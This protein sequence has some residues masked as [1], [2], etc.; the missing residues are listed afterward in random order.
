[1]KISVEWL[2]QYVD[3]DGSVEQLG[4]LFTRIGFTLE[5]SRQVGDDWM[6]DL[7]ITSNRPDCLGHIGL[8]REIAAA[9]GAR[10]HMPEL[11]LAD[12]TEQSNAVKPVEQWVSVEDNVPELCR[13]Y[14]ARVVDGVRVGDSPEWMRRRLEVIGQRSINNVVDVTN[15]VLM[16]IGQPLHSF[17][18]DKL[19]GG[20]VV[21][22]MARKGE[23]M[24]TIDQSEVVLDV[25]D[26][27][28]ADNDG[29]V[30]LAGVMGGLASEVGEDT[31]TVLLESAHF[32]PLSVRRTSRKLGIGSE[33]SYRF[34]R[35]VDIVMLEWASR[36]AASLLAELAGGKIAAGVIDV[37]PEQR[38]PRKV[39]LRMARLKKLLGIEIDSD[40][41]WELFGRLGFGCEFEQA[42]GA[43]GVVHCVIPSWRSDI[44]READLIEE[45]IR[46][47]GY[48]RI[49][50]EKSIRITVTTPDKT[51]RCRGR[52]VQAL[53]GCGLYET[54]NVSFLE[55]NY[56]RAFAGED[57]EPVR[58][59]DVSRKS[60]NA[61]RH[62]LLPSLLLARKRNQDAG[63]ERCDMYELGAVH[64]W[65]FEGFVG[66]N[67]T[68][69]GGRCATE[70]ESV[71]RGK[72]V[73]GKAGRLPEEAIKIGLCSDGEFRELRGVVEAVVGSLDRR[74]GVVLKPAN[75][76]W[77]ET[78]RAA[79][80]YIKQGGGQIL[81]GVM[82]QVSKKTADV[83]DLKC[84]PCMADIDFGVL[85]AL[86]G[87]VGKFRDFAR[88]PGIVR[89]LS[90]V[91]DEAVLW[92]DIEAGIYEAGIDELCDLRYVDTYRGKGVDSGKKSLT[93]S[94]TFRRADGT[95]THQQ[96]DEYQEKILTKLRER[97][98]FELRK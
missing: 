27:V 80:I 7:E 94:M 76:S 57:F 74:A 45:V 52:V 97:F 54:I 1:M 58:V 30:A 90:L 86:E 60:N 96:A 25:D 18:Y 24:T 43:G 8:A 84:Q 3:Y 35:N 95:L 68:N 64:S 37:W 62:S 34:E 51:Q 41:V 81:A 66:A 65:S 11:E 98:T 38:Q 31:K 88:F 87:S 89:D 91:I 13:R 32:A 50:T 55:D 82:G 72:G 48:D 42:G 77:A 69:I 93:L 49:P 73:S 85:V 19:N 22:R 70:G 5:E 61:L 29:P 9:T 40:F 78:G 21:V 23:K 14:T 44:S 2:R 16:E 10:F 63:N 53:N 79:E 47:Y 12:T 71:S 4:E 75:I 33:S 46:F 39:S 17:D 36:R 28:I 56:V 67:S 26:V 59:R 20:K 6:L 83:F 15:Y 92:A